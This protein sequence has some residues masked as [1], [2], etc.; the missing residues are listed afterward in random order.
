MAG[1]GA[2]DAAA[3]RRLH[4]EL[5]ARPARRGGHRV[6]EEAAAGGRGGGQ[7]VAAV[8]EEEGEEEEVKIRL[9]EMV[10][11]EEVE[12][13]VK[14]RAVEWVSE[15]G[16]RRRVKREV[17]AAEAGP[18]GRG[19]GRQQAGN[20][21]RGASR[22]RGVTIAHGGKGAKPWQSQIQVT[23][24][25]KKRQI[26]IARFAREE[27]AARAYDRVSIANSSHAKAKTNFPVA[28][29]RAEWGQLEAL[30]VDGAVALMREHAAAERQ[31]V[32][33]KASRFRGVS[34]V[35]GGKGSNPWSA[36]IGVTEDGKPRK[37]NI[38]TFAREEDA[39]RAYD[40]VSIAA[41]GHAEAET[42]FPVAQYREEWGQLEALGVDGA[43]ALMRELA[44]AERP[45]VM[46]K[47]SRFRG[48]SKQKGGKAKPWQAKIGV[49]EDGKHRNITIAYFSREEDAARTFDR[50]NIAK[51]GHAEAKTN[52]PVA[53]YQEEW[54]QLEALGVEG[55]VAREQQ[56]ARED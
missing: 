19:A 20:G 8:K 38:A 1:P 33:D 14:I 44:A 52:F 12:E 15:G 31:D 6:R 46:D 26:T 48:V 11:E 24:D 9:L 22:F 16:K 18:S 45:D 27:D 5:N 53:E 49:T 36:Q 28:E 40:R 35:N 25:G 56:Q 51:L 4:R 29:Y 23:E 50:V 10:K 37:I 21:G 32:M 17:V 43:V 3:A 34:K 47:A 2:Q 39:A 55:A 13:E 42:N 7:G 41:K 54:A 30:G